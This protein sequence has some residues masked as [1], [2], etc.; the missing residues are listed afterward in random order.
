MVD[1]QIQDIFQTI[2]KAREVDRLDI[3][4]YQDW[5]CLEGIFDQSQLMAK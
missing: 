2:F 3:D 1:N 4:Y 5:A